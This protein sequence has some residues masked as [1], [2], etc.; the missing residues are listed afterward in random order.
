VFDA[1]VNQWHNLLN[2]DGP[3]HPGG[4]TMATEATAPLRPWVDH[5]PPEIAWDV[6][7]DTTPMHI[8]VLRACEKSP[9]AD[10]LDFLGKKTKFRD[11]AKQINAFA[12]ALQKKLGVKKGTRVAMLLQYAVLR[13]RLL[14]HPQ[15]RRHGGELQPALHD[16]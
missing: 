13:G 4:G 7:I 12:G 10:A 9:D 16:R 6:Q 5:Y 11:L 1:N 2:R 3:K 15:D 8:Q 14:R